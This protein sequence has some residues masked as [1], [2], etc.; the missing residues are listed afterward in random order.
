MP[1][2][3]LQSLFIFIRRFERSEGACLL[4]GVI[5]HG[6]ATPTAREHHRQCPC[7]GI[8]VPFSVLPVALGTGGRNPTETSHPLK[9]ASSKRPVA[10]RPPSSS[11]IFLF[12]SFQWQFWQSCLCLCWGRGPWALTGSTGL[13]TDQPG[14]L[15]PIILQT[16][17]AAYSLFLALIFFCFPIACSDL[18]VA[19]EVHEASF[20]VSLIIR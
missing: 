1:L 10:L 4:P 15:S 6:A 3:F 11:Y 17:C 14:E 19:L 9:R 12:P 8:S 2:G 5:A 7:L 13:C 16:A 18:L 20:P